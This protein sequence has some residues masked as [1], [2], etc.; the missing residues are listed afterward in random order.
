MIG[1][2]SRRLRLCL[3]CAATAALTT[4]AGAQAAYLQLGT[5][6]TS[7]ATTSLKGSTGAPEFYVTNSNAGNAGIKADSAGGT[8]PAIVG[9]H[10]SA[11]GNGPAVQGISD[12]TQPASYALF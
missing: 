3:L 11:A 4:A 10:T 9:V 7:N 1:Q 12:S 8:G 2:T 5:S 6:N